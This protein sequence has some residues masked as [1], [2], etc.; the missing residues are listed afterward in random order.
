MY[1]YVFI[2]MTFNFHFIPLLLLV[3]ITVMEIEMI[4]TNFVTHFYSL[5][6]GVY[7]ILFIPHN[8]NRLCFQS[9]QP[10]L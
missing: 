6:E 4:Q 10:P 9:T 7:Y 5:K 2:D 8:S 1:T 3:I